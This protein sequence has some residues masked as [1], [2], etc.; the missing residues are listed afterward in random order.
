MGKDIDKLQ[1]SA[2]I[3]NTVTTLKD[4]R[5]LLAF[6]LAMEDIHATY[7]APGSPS[8]EDLHTEMALKRVPGAEQALD[9]WTSRVMV[10]LKAGSDN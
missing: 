2:D 3:A 6:D 10:N 8:Q 7:G 4:K 1:R 9:R 5:T